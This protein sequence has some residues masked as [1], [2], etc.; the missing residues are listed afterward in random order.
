LPPPIIR[1]ARTVHRR[2]R[3][4]RRQPV[5]AASAKG[6]RASLGGL[7]AVR[8]ARAGATMAQLAFRDSVMGRS[9]STRS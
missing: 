9:S 8:P 1:A 3:R 2:D 4:T 7:V 5:K 6:E